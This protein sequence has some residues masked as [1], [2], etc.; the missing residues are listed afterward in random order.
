MNPEL[1][2]KRDFNENQD[3]FRRHAL[4][5]GPMSPLRQRPILGL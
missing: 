3:I 2:A 5:K 1:Q 4:D